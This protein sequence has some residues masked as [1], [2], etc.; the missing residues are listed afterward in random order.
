MLLFTLLGGWLVSRD[1]TA[2][3]GGLK[4][5][6]E[7]L[8]NGDVATIVPGAS[9]RDEVGSM[10]ATVLVFRDHMIEAERLRADQEEAKRQAAAA[11]RAEMNRM[12]D[13]FEGKIGGLV[14]MLSSDS[15][16]LKEAA[17]SLTATADQSH[18]QATAV[19]SA[20]EQAGVGLHSV[21]SASEELTASIAEISRQMAQS[22]KITSKAVDDARHTDTIV[23][24]LADGAEKIGAVV[25]L[26]TDIASQ[27]NLLALNATI[28]A[29]RAVMPGR[30][31]PW[32]RPKSK[33]LPPRRGRQRRRS[34]RKLPISRQRPERPSKPFGV[35]PPSSRRS[36]RSPQP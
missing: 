36:A 30:A 26:I 9:R 6:M 20:A 5:A 31:S 7:R 2:S 35:S 16:A 29:A 23:R 34:A 19:A 11:Q 3:L 8:A 25:G 21:A 12:A 24:A 27:T 18:Q 28:E 1:I 15:T 13:G 17:R 14:G 33:A 22:S 32:W 4:A 10:A